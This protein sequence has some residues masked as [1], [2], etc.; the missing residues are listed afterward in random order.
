[1]LGEG[2]ITV[3]TN[4]YVALTEK[5]GDMRVESITSTG[6]D[7][8]LYAPD[9][10]LDADRDANTESDIAG[11]NITLVAASS[12]VNP[13]HVEVAG[14]VGNPARLVRAGNPPGGI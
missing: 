12:F 10:I 14:E 6:S 2:H 1:D 3:L 5:T 7:V 13:D 8:L 11:R 9:R 4:G